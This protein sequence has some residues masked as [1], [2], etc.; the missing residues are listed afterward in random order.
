MQKIIGHAKEQA[1]EAQERALLAGDEKTRNA[2]LELA[3][4][5][6]RVG[7][8]YTEIQK[9]R[10]RLIL[11]DSEGARGTSFVTS[12]NQAGIRKPIVFGGDQCP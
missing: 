1:L 5:W 3:R 10:D 4:I 9:L 11:D 2:W 7:E 6:D 8:Q 12:L